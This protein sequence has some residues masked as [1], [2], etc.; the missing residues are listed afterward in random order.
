V[1]AEKKMVVR[2]AARNDIDGI[3]EVLKS[4]K[5][6]KEAWAGNEKW[7]RRALERWLNLENY[8]LCVA[9]YNERIVGFVD[10]CVFPSF[11]EGAYQGIIN[12]LF[13]HSAF[14]GKGVGAMLVKA[15]VEEADAKG[16][17]ELHVSTERENIKARRLYATYGFTEE[18]LLLE[19]VGE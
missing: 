14:Q 1:N 17:G 18:R 4:T 3:I 8:V 13:V 5:L 6:G 7:A 19:R 2:K 15:V 16:L 12:H 11:W 9:E 10:F